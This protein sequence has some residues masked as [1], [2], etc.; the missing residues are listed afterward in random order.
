MQID[1]LFFGARRQ[2]KDAQTKLHQLLE[3]LQDGH[4]GVDASE[5]A[6]LIKAVAKAISEM[7]SMANDW[8]QKAKQARMGE[9][10]IKERLE[11]KAGVSEFAKSQL[12]FENA[13]SLE[14]I[15]KNAIFKFDG[16]V[17]ILGDEE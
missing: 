7:D 9:A 2:L 12:Y 13:L 6:D 1:E 8:Q 14:D 3:L 11:A 10:L 16:L 5:V 4:N 15:K 17:D